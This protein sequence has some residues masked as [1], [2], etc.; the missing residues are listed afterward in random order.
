MSVD[1]WGWQ[2][3]MTSFIACTCTICYTLYWLWWMFNQLPLTVFCGVRNVH[4][5][6]WRVTMTLLWLEPSGAVHSF[7]AESFLW[8][9]YILPQ[10]FVFMAWDS[11]ILFVAVIPPT[12]AIAH[13]QPQLCWSL[14]WAIYS[15]VATCFNCTCTS[16]RSVYL[17]SS[18]II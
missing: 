7:V 17:S 2:V 14:N 15:S 6:L 9:D 16:T 12:T 10:C 11:S 5:V 13:T 1:H 8:S 3:V 4:R 18:S